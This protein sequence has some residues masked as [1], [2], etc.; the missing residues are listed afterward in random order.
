MTEIAEYQAPTATVDVHQSVTQSQ[1]RQTALELAD[2]HKIA[3]AISDS[4]FVPKHLR[5]KPEETAVA[6][7]YGATVG[8]DPITAVQQI[9]AIGG[10]PALYARAMVAIVL[11]AGHEIWTEEERPGFVTVAGRRKG[12]EHVTRVTWTSELAAQAGYTSN[13]KYRTDPR[14]M[15]YARASGD[16]ARRI[17]PDALMGMAYNVEEMELVPVQAERVQAERVQSTSSSSKDR[18]RSAIAAPQTSGSAGEQAAAPSAPAAP[19]TAEPDTPTIT[20]EQ[21]V[22]LHTLVSKLGLSREQKLGGCSKIIGRQIASTS[23]LTFDEARAV[24]DSLEQRVPAAAPPE[25]EVHEAEIVDEAPA[26]PAASADEHEQ[27]WTKILATG[28]KLGMTAWDVEE[29]LSDTHQVPPAGA[30]LEQ[31]QQVLTTLQDTNGEAAGQ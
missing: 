31:L 18:V 11:K 19:P 10:T 28:G 22:K 2:A 30:T 24:I 1:I 20:R 8:F 27:L 29:L 12:S 21:S 14:S 16:V 5:G 26:A 3:T 7:L 6:I 13:A 17:A 23:D 15:L 4:A 25:P 9:Y